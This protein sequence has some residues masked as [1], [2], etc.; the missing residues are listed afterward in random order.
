MAA[1]ANSRSRSSCVRTSS[2][3][4]GEAS[5]VIIPPIAVPYLLQQRAQFAQRNRALVP[6]IDPAI[7]KLP[8]LDLQ[9]IADFFGVERLRHLTRV[10]TLG[11][12]RAVQE[13]IKRR[14][15]WLA[16]HRAATASAHMLPPAVPW[17]RSRRTSPILAI[18]P[19]RES[20]KYTGPKARSSC[21][22]MPASRQR[23]VRISPGVGP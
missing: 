7:A 16:A 4:S 20:V 3:S 1:I 10:D 22:T 9:C 14:R 5:Y 12:I 19:S 23:S 11:Q 15:D 8:R 17:P 6:Q 13:G 21:G 2:R 18:A